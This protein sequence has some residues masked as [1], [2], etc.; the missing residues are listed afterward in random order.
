MLPNDRKYTKEHEWIA[1]EGEFCRIGITDHAQ[2]QLGDITFVELPEEGDQF[3]AGDTLVVVESVKAASPVYCPIAGEGVEINAA[4]EDTPE[5]VN[6]TPYEAWMAKLRPANVADLDALMDAD[7]Y[8]AF[9][10]E[11]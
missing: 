6:E 4:L 8:A 3:Q 2:S 1:L 7:T 9:L 11:A 5:A 10:A